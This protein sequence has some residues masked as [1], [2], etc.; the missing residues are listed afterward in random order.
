MIS[1]VQPDSKDYIGNDDYIRYQFEDYLNSL[2]SVMRYHQYARSF[3]QPPP[4]F[5]PDDPAEGDIHDFNK[6]Y[7]QAWEKTENFN[8]W[9][10]MADEFI[11]NFIEPCHIGHSLKQPGS[12]N[13]N[14]ANFSI[15]LH[16]RPIQLQHHLMSLKRTSLLLRIL[17]P[18]RRMTMS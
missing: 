3:H 14:I 15:L 12:I 16:L 18:K 4:G 5:S 9:H 7:I 10:A 11:F 2:I 1:T 6:S 8:I 13:K 17:P